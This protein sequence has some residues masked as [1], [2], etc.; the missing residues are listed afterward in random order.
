M[1]RALRYLLRIFGVL[2]IVAG[3]L[4][5]AGAW[6]LAQPLPLP[7]TP[8]EFDVKQG[9][10]LRAVA[11]DLAAQ[12]VLPSDLPL[13]ALARWRGVDRTIKAGNYEIES[14]ITLPQL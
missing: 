9:A 12:R 10:T 7:S 6:W 2:A 3:A 4:T 1:N 8:L 5:I 13:I 11:R 14:G